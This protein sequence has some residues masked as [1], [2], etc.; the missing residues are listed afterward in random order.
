MQYN[1]HSM[2][3]NGSYCSIVTNQTLLVSFF[4]LFYSGHERGNYL[5]R[6]FKFVAIISNHSIQKNVKI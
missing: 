3:L 1:L 6:F 4:I 5:W 2:Y